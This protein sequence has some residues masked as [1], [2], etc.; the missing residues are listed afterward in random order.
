MEHSDFLANLPPEQKIELTRKSNWKGLIHL[1]GHFGFLFLGSIWIIQGWFLWPLI[2][3]THGFALVFLFTLEHECTHKTPFE[4]PWLNE[5]IGR[6]CGLILLLPFEWFRYFHLAHHRWT[7]IPE[8]DPELLTPKPEN[9]LDLVLYIAG[10][11]YWISMIRQLIMNAKGNAFVDYI[12]RTAR[13]RVKL[14]SR[15]LL[16]ILIIALSSLVMSEFLL[17]VWIFPAMLG[18]PFLRLYLL[19]EHG[20]CPHVSD[21]FVNSRTIYT[22]KVMRFFAWNMPYHAEHHTFP[23]VPFHRLP[24]LNM[25]TKNHLR[26]TSIG[27]LNST[28]SRLSQIKENS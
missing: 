7:N 17:W 6:F 9:A 27:Y 28:K 23:S 22:H 1:I 11:T 8:K 19:S 13:S 18:Q 14:E 5:W 4:T 24:D 20:G 26:S 3:I 12:P 21:M 10:F 25:L 2:L 15:I 16:A